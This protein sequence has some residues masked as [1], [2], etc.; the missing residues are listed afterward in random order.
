MVLCNLYDLLEL[1]EMN[2]NS[3]NIS[4]IVS[5][6][7]YLRLN[8]ISDKSEVVQHGSSTMEY[9]YGMKI[10]FNATSDKDS[11]TYSINGNNNIEKESC[12]MIIVS[13][14]KGFVD[15]A[16]IHTVSNE[17]ICSCVSATGDKLNG[18]YLINIAISFIKSIKDKYGIKRIHLRDTAS[19]LCTTRHKIRLSILN[20]LLYGQTW[21]GRFGF[22]PI[23]E[24]NDRVKIMDVYNNNINIHKTAKTSDV[25]KLANYID[26]YIKNEKYITVAEHRIIMSVSERTQ[27]VSYFIKKLMDNNC[28]SFVAYIYEK[29]FDDLGYVD[30]AKDHSFYL[31]I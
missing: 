19:K 8:Y 29:I 25:K 27:P 20:T 26:D 30:T 10:W 4:E 15:Y 5:N 11:I 18:T 3:E 6:C 21:Y 12:L 16:T 13:K 14:I 2:P 9:E 28:C 24:K 31:N 22:R 17:G 1:H 7:D 23:P